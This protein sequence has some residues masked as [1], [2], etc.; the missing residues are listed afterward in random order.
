M[1]KTTVAATLLGIGVQGIYYSVFIFLPTYLGE[2]RGLD[3]VGTFSF[4]SV[5]IV[6]SFVGYVS[7]GFFLDWIGRRPTFLIFFV[8]SA[9]SVSL[10]VFTPAATP[11][12]GVPIIFLLGFFASGQAGGTGAYLAELFPTKIRATGQGFAYNFG[13]GLAAFGPLTVGLA[14]ETIGWGNSIMTIAVI[15][16]VTG[17]IALSMLPETKN[18]ELVEL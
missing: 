6:G 1:A 8:G 5:A 9:L 4:T 15:G 12:L 3:I 2:E 13:S 11:E 17:L 7:S 18:S 16:A 14:A 10:F